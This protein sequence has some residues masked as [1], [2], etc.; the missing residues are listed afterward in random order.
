MATGYNS[1]A[2]KSDRGKRGDLFFIHAQEE[3]LS[4]LLFRGLD[5][6]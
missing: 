1:K 5:S 2:R 6:R 4:T 3:I